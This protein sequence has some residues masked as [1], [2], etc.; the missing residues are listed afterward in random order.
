MSNKGCMFLDFFDFNLYM[1]DIT[2]ALG[3]DGKRAQ[4]L[5]V[6]PAWRLYLINWVHMLKR[7]IDYVQKLQMVMHLIPC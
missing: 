5:V 4:L 2:Y 3:S 6:A 1:H 7:F